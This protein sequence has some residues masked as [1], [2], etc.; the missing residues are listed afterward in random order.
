MGATKNLSCTRAA[1]RPYE[2][3]RSLLHHRA[4]E[5]FQRATNC[6]AGHADV[7]AA[8]LRIGS[9]IAVGVPVHIHVRAIRDEAPVGGMPPVT[10]VFIEWEAAR[11]AGFFPHAVAELSVW[12][13]TA[14]GSRLELQGIYHPP[15]GVLG[16]AIDAA[17]GHRVAEATVAHLLDDVVDE[18][19]RDIPVA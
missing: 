15:L 16:S 9:G 4:L 11:G 5:V 6:A 2:A 8:K 7:L 19:R 12:P 10:R 1:D 14:Q 13:V 18:L 3:V 17:V